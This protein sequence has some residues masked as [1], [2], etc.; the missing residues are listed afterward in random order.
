MKTLDEQLKAYQPTGQALPK[1]FYEQ[2][3]HMVAWELLGRFLIRQF[4]KSTIIGQ[5]REVAAYRGETDYSSEGL[6]QGAGIVDVSKKYNQFLLDI[7]TGKP[8]SPS[9]ITL[10]G[11]AFDFEDVIRVQGP[12]KL[13]EALSIDE[14]FNG[15][16]ITVASNLW[17]EGH[18]VPN[19][20]KKRRN[21][22]S[23]T[24]N[25]LGYWYIK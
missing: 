25:C 12:G 9:C 13:T 11:A 7:A 19:D 10:R 1:E 8:G 18:G 24:S 3:S 15:H 17:I 6:M 16:D 22:K 5:I 21:L 20:L 23:Y 4:D 2:N 14:R